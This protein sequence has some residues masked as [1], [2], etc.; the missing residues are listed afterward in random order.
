MTQNVYLAAAALG[1]GARYVHTL[2]ADEIRRALKLP[3][4]DVPIALMLLGK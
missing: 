3:P 4:G 2:N 1:I